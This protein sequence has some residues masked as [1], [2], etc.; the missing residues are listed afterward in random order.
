M[1]VRGGCIGHI[2]RA[3]A[4]VGVRGPLLLG[5]A[6]AGVGRIDM[7]VMCLLSFRGSAY[8]PRGESGRRMMGAVVRVALL[9]LRLSGY[10]IGE[11]HRRYGEVLSDRGGVQTGMQLPVL[12]S[13]LKLVRFIMVIR[14]IS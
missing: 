9:G 1:A 2:T 14:V 11:Y 5:R 6:R 3:A 12:I 13:P 4:T 10:G 8:Q 7:Q